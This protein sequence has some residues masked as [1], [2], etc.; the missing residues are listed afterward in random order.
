MLVRMCGNIS[1]DSVWYIARKQ[2]AL[3][4]HNWAVGLFFVTK[5]LSSTLKRSKNSDTI[6]EIVRGVFPSG[7]WE[8]SQRKQW[9]IVLVC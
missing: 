4:T 6:H 3:K 7:V 2:E 9:Y 5:V 8:Y 1:H